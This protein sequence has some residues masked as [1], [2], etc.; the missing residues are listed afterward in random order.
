MK[1]GTERRNSCLFAPTQP[2]SEQERPIC[3]HSARCKDCP[4]AG[5]G[6]ICWHGDDSCLRTDIEE[7]REREEKRK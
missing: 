7:I 3:R 2:L 4:H 1:Y 6:F 5:H